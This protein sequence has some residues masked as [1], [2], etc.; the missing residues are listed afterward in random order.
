MKKFLLAVAVAIAGILYL[1]TASAQAVAPKMGVSRYG[2]RVGGTTKQYKVLDSVAL[3]AADASRT[4]S[5]DVSGYSSLSVQVDLTRT[6]ATDLQL[7]CSVSLNGGVS[8]GSLT[9]TSVSSGTGTI[10]VFHDVC[11]IGAGSTCLTGTGNIVLDYDV[12]KYDAFKCVV[13]G[14]SGGANDIVNVY[15]VAAV[16]Q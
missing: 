9:S 4:F 14:T 16:G 5:L 10:S 3:N 7:T 15:V 11:T 12:R 13:S 2:T 8:F 6:A 1:A